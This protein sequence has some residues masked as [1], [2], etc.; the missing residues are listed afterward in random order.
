LRGWAYGDRAKTFEQHPGRFLPADPVEEVDVQTV[1]VQQIRGASELTTAI[2]TM[3]AV[4]PTTSSRTVANWEVGKT[5]L[6]YIA[7]G[8]V[9]AG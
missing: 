9:R 1:V 2:F 3:E 6:V 5:T 8:E 4:V 7:K